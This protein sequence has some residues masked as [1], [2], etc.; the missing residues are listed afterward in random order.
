MYWKSIDK[1]SSDYVEKSK[2]LSELMDEVVYLMIALGVRTNTSQYTREK[3]NYKNFITRYRLEL[4]D[5][6]IEENK[7]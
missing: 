7:S 2:H 6:F 5:E 1:N 4:G 3:N